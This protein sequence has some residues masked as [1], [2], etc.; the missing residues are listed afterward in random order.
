M[1]IN[2]IMGTGLQGIQ[3]GLHGMQQNA[4]RIASY[5]TSEGSDQIGDV[6]ADI[7]GLKESELLVQASAKVVESASQTLGTLLDVSA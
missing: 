6:A 1:A 3:T 7:V 5:G 4:E 2:S